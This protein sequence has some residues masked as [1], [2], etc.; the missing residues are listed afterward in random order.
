[1]AMEYILDKS[2]FWAP[3][4]EEPY[5]FQCVCICV[6][7]RLEEFLNSHFRAELLSTWSSDWAEILYT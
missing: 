6:C 2:V 7:L 4:S 5:I 3:N 1:M